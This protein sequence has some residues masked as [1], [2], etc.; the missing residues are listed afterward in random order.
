MYFSLFMGHNPGSEVI[1]KVIFIYTAL[2][3]T[4]LYLAEVEFEHFRALMRQTKSNNENNLKLKWS[5]IN[6]DSGS[7]DDKV[8]VFD[9]SCRKDNRK[10]VE[11][12]V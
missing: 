10:Q 4:V 8:E 12:H 2:F 7:K 1:I 9:V 11:I 5:Q 3:K 6:V